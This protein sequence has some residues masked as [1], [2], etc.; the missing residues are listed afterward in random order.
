MACWPRCW[1]I[2][3]IFVI[4]PVLFFLLDFMLAHCRTNHDAASFEDGRWEACEHM[5]VREIQKYNIL[6]RLCN[7]VLV[8][9]TYLV[10]DIKSVQ[11]SNQVKYYNLRL[12]KLNNLC[13]KL[14]DLNYYNSIMCFLIT[15]NYLFF[16][17]YFLCIFYHRTKNY[18]TLNN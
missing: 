11:I 13:Y 12:R 17:V 6:C 18:Q 10:T 3:W 8:T 1:L 9:F 2:R 4:E 7:R 15:S 14:F 5:R 16:I